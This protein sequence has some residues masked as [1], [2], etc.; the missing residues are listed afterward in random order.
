MQ[1]VPQTRSWFRLKNTTSPRDFGV[2]KWSSR[3][4]HTGIIWAF[5]AVA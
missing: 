5:E 3:V 1:S 2:G 4:L